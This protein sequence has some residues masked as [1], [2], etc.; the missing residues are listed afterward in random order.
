MTPRLR[1]RLLRRYISA[2]D[3]PAKYRLVRW[4]GRHAMSRVG[5]AA[6]VHPGVMLWMNP[7]DWIEYLML[8]DGSYEP[9][10]LDF[11]QRNLKPSESA[12]LAG[13]NNGLHAIVAA[14]AVGASGKVV[15]CEPQPEALLRARLNMELNGMS[16]RSLRLVACAL[17]NAR[18]LTSMAWSAPDNPGAASLLT[19]GPGFTVPLL[20]VTELAAALELAPIRLMLLDV[21]GYEMEVLG[22]LGELRPAIVIV[23]DD[24]TYS[25]GPGHS[26]AALYQRLRDLGYSLRDLHGRPVE[27]PDAVLAERNLV[28]VLDGSEVE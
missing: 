22:G 20:S 10:T 18:G 15:G 7:T 5:I 16:D 1:D 12:I 3:H 26:R 13:V 6:S 27:A 28:G 4:L 11:I 2:P 9:L 23:E 17:G 24:P 14:R 19:Q 21:Q 8:R 25:A